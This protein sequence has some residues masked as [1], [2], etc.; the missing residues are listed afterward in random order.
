MRRSI[1]CL[2]V[3]AATMVTAGCAATG[4]Q[5]EA[6]SW[7]TAQ[8]TWSTQ[9]PD[10][11]ERGLPGLVYLAAQTLGDRAEM[12]DRTRP[13][14]VSTVI[15]V[16][17]L[18]SSST[19]GRLVSQL[20]A[21]RLHQRGYLVRDMN[22]MRALV[23]RPGT[24]ELVLTREAAKIGEAANAQA[25]VAGTY[26]IGGQEIY[27]SLRLIDAVSSTV[28]SS[29]DVVIPWNENTSA[30]FASEQPMDKMIT[31]ERFVEL[32]RK[33]ELESVP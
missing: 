21:N 31:F 27:L 17:N 15:S 2:V 9:R 14:I 4:R 13:I 11:Q 18:E 7:S 5:A 28:L 16:N 19:F 32:A 12:L 10:G 3:A 1:I 20:V 24:G 29:T 22:F 33:A 26:A 6:D 30:L 8:P 23:L 25:V